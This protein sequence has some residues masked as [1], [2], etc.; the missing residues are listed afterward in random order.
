MVNKLPQIWRIIVSTLIGLF[1]YGLVVLVWNRSYHGLNVLIS[2]HTEFEYDHDLPRGYDSKTVGCL[3]TLQSAS[4]IYAQHHKGSLPPMQNSVVTLKALEPYLAQ[5]SEYSAYNPA[6]KTPFTPNAALS[7]KK[8]GRVSTGGRAIL[9]YDADPPAGYRE[10]YYVTIKGVVGHV[11]V[12]NLPK[13]LLRQTP[14]QPV[15]NRRHSGTIVKGDA[16]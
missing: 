16:E 10:S 13:L 1:L 2:D 3:E 14:Q 6:T 5:Y 7:N 9:F 11:P 4:I 8:M 12:G 15:D